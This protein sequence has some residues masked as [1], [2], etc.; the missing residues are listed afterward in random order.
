LVALIRVT[1]RE[2]KF[3]F[4]GRA[5]ETSNPLFRG[6]GDQSREEAGS[7]DQPVL[8][9]LYPNDEVKT[10]CE[11]ALSGGF[12]KSAEALYAY[13]AVILDDVESEFF[14]PDQSALLQRFVSERGGGFIML[15][16]MES[17]Q[18]GK[19]LRTPV[20]DMLP[21]YLDRTEQAGVS[22]QLHLKLE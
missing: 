2:P 6:F 12:P 14:T 9:R 5:G 22:G 13:H 10:R 15:G 20:G 18:Q 21:V 19:Y 17:F 4:L 3:N 11:P 7:Y 1:R 8:T 16:G